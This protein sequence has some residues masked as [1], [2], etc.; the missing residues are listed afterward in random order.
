LPARLTAIASSDKAYRVRAAA[1]GALADLKAPGAYDALA[2]AV[3]TDSPDNVVRDAALG[4]LGRLGD[5]RAVPL[6]L[7]WSRP[8]KDQRTRQAAML[9]VGRLDKKNK[10]ITKT[11]LAYLH[12]PSFDVSLWGLFAIGERGDADAIGPLEDLL[13]SDDVTANQKT[14]IESQIEVL[15]AHAA[16]K[17]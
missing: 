3:N 16:S 2:A 9:A 1:L 12:E 14:M 11:L 7:E 5:D 13:K 15:Q 8:G 10:E 6:L 4:G 17:N